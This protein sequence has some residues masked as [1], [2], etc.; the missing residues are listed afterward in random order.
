MTAS[1]V[2]LVTCPTQRHAR[3]IATMLVRKRV[4]ACV[5]VL[6]RVE[7]FFWWKG[8]IDHADETLLIIK[9]TTRAFERLRRTVCALHPYE[10]PEVLALSI[11][12]AHHP[13]LTWLQESVGA[14][15]ISTRRQDADE[16]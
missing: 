6:P 1:L 13:Y 10:V 2:V 3:Q 11:T 8:R 7:S 12:A 16:R 15:P 4:A 9:T 5:N 14:K